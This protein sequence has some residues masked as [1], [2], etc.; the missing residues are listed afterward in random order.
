MYRTTVLTI[1]ATLL[2]AIGPGTAAD[3]EIGRVIELSPERN[4]IQVHDRIYKVENLEKMDSRGRIT[5]AAPEEL[6]EGCMVQIVRGDREEYFWHARSLRILPEGPEA[7]DG[8]LEAGSTPADAT[9]ETAA[10]PTRSTLVY[11]NGVW[12]N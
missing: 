4:F 1:L 2:L 10:E 7:G 5:A 12:H 3:L 9:G 11:E 8:D 6:A